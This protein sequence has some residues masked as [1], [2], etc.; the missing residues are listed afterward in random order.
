MITETG[1]G[2]SRLSLC[3]YTGINDLYL[4]LDEHFLGLRL[5]LGAFSVAAA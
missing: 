4:R 3:C 1:F 2:V 5:F